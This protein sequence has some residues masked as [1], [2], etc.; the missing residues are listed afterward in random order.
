[1]ACDTNDY[2]YPLLADVYYPIVQQGPYGDL[3]KNWVLDKTVACGFAP[4]G[5]KSKPIVQAGVE[6]LL[7]N[8][9]VG[10]TRCDIR[11]ST[12]GTVDAITNVLITNIRDMNGNAIYYET[13]GIR[14]GKNTLF[15]VAGNDPIVGPFG[16][17][18]E[19]WRVL[20]RRSDNQGV[21]V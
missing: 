7:D 16:G 12:N 2:M 11:T 6:L 3:N 19:Y 14:K 13:S 17:K 5:R 15:E 21:D 4:A 9:L 18:V 10:R 8:L 1:M 20:L